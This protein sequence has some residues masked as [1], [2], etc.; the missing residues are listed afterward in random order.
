MALHEVGKRAGMIDGD[1]LVHDS[2][3]R[4]DP[5]APGLAGLPGLQFLPITFHFIVVEIEHAG[6]APALAAL[7]VAGTFWRQGFGVGRSRKRLVVG[8]G[9]CKEKRGPRQY[10]P[11]AQSG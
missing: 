2:G 3:S 4:V 1:V 11:L 9:K 5:H 10:M 8:H 7:V 6:V